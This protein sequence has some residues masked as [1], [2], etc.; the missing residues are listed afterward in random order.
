[1]KKVVIL[2]ILVWT[3]ISATF[4]QSSIENNVGRQK[5]TYRQR[6]NVGF[7]FGFTGS[8][9]SGGKSDFIQAVASDLGNENIVIAFDNRPRISV[10]ASILVSC[11]LKNWLQL[12]SELTYLNMGQCFSGDGYMLYEEY[13]GNYQ[14]FDFFMRMKMKVNYLQIP[15]LLKVITKEGFYVAAGPHLAITTHGKI[16]V[17]V[18]ADGDSERNS[19][20]MPGISPF[21]YGFNVGIGYQK[22]GIGVDLRFVSDL[23][24][25]FRKGSNDFNLKNKMLQI[26][27]CLFPG[28]MD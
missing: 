3:M 17:T 6:W 25:T 2:T 15:L 1:M 28:E 13:Y 8:W 23:K 18:K 19:E 4:S 21:N 26:S 7:S 24:D 22:K 27:L 16:K 9:W 11:Y 14:R 20:K 5:P 10:N 12:Q